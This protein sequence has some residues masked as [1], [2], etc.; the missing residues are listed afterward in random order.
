MAPLLPPTLPDYNKA[1][2]KA[3]I[4]KAISDDNVLCAR[5]ILGNSNIDQFKELTY[6]LVREYKAIDGA[7]RQLDIGKDTIERDKNKEIADLRETIRQK[8]I[9]IADMSQQIRRLTSGSGR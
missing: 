3:E 1:L 2:N 4:F 9:H 6:V 7:Y 5:I 8:D